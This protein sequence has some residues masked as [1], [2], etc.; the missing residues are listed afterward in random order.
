MKQLADL[1]NMVSSIF[2]V[3]SPSTI[4]D[5]HAHGISQLSIPINGVM[6][7]IVDDE[8][9]IIPPTMAVFIPKNIKHCIQKINA[10]TVIETIYFTDMYQNHLPHSTQS[11]YLSELSRIVISKICSINKE[12]FNNTKVKNLINVLLDELNIGSTQSYSLKI[13]THPILL[14]VYA[15]FAT[16]SDSYPSLIDAAKHVHLSSRTLL[17]LF[18]K[19]LGISFVLWKQQ[20]IFIKALEL[21]M[22][23]N[24]TTTVA[25][26][27]GYN[28]DSAF[29]TMFKK[30]SGGLLPSSF[31]Q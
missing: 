13:P 8:L 16:S 7:I 17:R 2:G 4:K 20:F 1:D 25:Y 15:L 27:L 5:F 14:K 23:D 29:I 9:F 3:A 12:D 6:Y 19:E 28:S 21:L 30:M 31:F 10:K 11:F 18:K 26:K 24:S 22:T